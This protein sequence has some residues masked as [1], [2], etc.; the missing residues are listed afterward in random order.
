MKSQPS[1]EITVII[2]S[3]LIINEIILSTVAFGKEDVY[4]EWRLPSPSEGKKHPLSRKRRYLEFPV[5]SSFQ[6][7]K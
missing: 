4:N 7:G 3:L 5:G 1:F 2:L 6:L